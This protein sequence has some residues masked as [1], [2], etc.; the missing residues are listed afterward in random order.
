MEK[1]VKITSIIVA[2]VL[3]L[4]LLGYYA[5]IPSTSNTI[6][7]NGQ[8]QVNALPD[9]V[10]VYFNVE[11]KGTTSAEATQKNSDLVDKLTTEIIKLGFERKD[12]QTQNFNVNPE[13]DWINGVQRQNGYIATHSIRV[14]M[15]STESSKIGDLID[16]G[17]N[18]G[19][20]ISYINFELSQE[21]QNSYKAEALKLAAQDARIKAE[22][23]AQGFDKKL[24]NLV[25]TSV[26]NFNYYPWRAYDNAGGV[27]MSV[28]EKATAT[29]ITPSSQDISASVSAVYKI[30]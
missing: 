6:T 24:G 5:L 29:S 30:R 11:T 18:A 27:A 1:S 8:A 16:A 14:E 28:S 9:L 25:S 19:V 10:T 13:Y 17:V 22:S 7:V 2:G 26:D 3:I 15:P 20:G 21:K 4:A 12:I 23:V